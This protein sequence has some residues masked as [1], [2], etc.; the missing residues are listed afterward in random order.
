MNKNQIKRKK[1]LLIKVSGLVQGVGFR[2]FIYKIALENNIAGWVLNTSESVE[3]RAESDSLSINNFIDAIK[4]NSPKNASIEKIDFVESPLGNFHDF[5]ILKSVNESDNI[6]Q[7]SPDIA[8]CNECLVD[9]KK[10]ANRFDYPFINCT[11]CGPRFSIIKDLPYDR[12]N[13][14][15]YEFAMCDSCKNEYENV[16]DRRFH[17]QP[18]ACIDCGPSYFMEYNGKKVHDIKEILKLIID[19]ISQGKVITFKGLG[20]F[21]LVCDAFNEN[22]VKKLREIKNREGKPFAVMFSNIKKVEKYAFVS[23]AEEEVLISPKRPVVLLKAKSELP[24]QI[25]NGLNTLGVIMPYMPIHYLIFEQLKTDAIIYTSGNISEEP[26]V[27]DNESAKNTFGDRADAFIFHNRQIYNRVDDSVTF[28]TNDIEKV[29]RRS[30]G[31]VPVPINLNTNADGILACGAELK[32][33][34]CIGKNNYAYIS[35]HIGDL[36]NLETYDFFSETIERFKKLFRVK[37]ELLVTDMHPDYLST[38]YAQEMGTE[39]VKIQHHHAHI[40]SCMA[41]NGIDEDIIGISLDGTGY[42]SDGNIWGGEFLLCNLLDF[43]RVIYFNYTPMPGGEVAIREPW[44]MAVSYLFKAFGDDFD[45]LDLLFL[46]NI[47]GEKIAIITEMLKKNINSQFTSSAGRLFD[48]ISA[49]LNLCSYSAFEAE[50]PMRLES[51]IDESIDQS[52]HFLINETVDISSIIRKVVIDLQNNILP[53]VISTKFHNTIVKIILECS[54]I[55]KDKYNVHKVALSGGL[56]QNRYILAKAEKLL[57]KSGFVVYSQSKVPSNDG[58]VS[59]G[60]LAI[61][62]KRREVGCV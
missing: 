52:Y 29:I 33:T 13:T 18:V 11:N 35:Q 4:N 14:T 15:M 31:Y 57:K 46:K 56:F 22:T 8:V 62:A 43:K 20:G 38:K 40:A 10:Q 42:G 16:L 55:M 17:A 36:K 7:I 59:L 41:E 34:F 6:T 37:Q 2:P 21:N 25:S 12:K 53:E 24:Y 51:L 19:L 49:M 61:A 28:V 26:I 48:G 9:M 47:N 30:R 27:I 50:A 44:R 1:S 58:G 3:I 54:M 45:K 32:N 39:L 60:Q 23:K 5:K